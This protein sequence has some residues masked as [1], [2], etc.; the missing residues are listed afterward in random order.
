VS[1]VLNVC[2]LDS[3]FQGRLDWSGTVCFV[4]DSVVGRVREQSEKTIV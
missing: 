4:V 2:D 3:K 1:Q